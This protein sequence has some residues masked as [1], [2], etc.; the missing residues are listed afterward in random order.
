MVAS[1]GAQGNGKLVL[2]PAGITLASPGRTIQEFA[3]AAAGF[4][5]VNVSA[6][7]MPV[8]RT[9]AGFLRKRSNRCSA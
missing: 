8:F 1:I 4:V 6:E 3:T 9:D 7:K 2:S 5:L